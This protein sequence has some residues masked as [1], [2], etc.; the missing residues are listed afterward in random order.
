MGPT[1]RCEV[2]ER[3]GLVGESSRMRLVR[4]E[5]LRAAALRAPLV[6]TGET[7]TGKELAARA[8]HR[9]SGRS[10]GPFVAL[11]CGS[12]T[13]TLAEDALFGHERGA[14]TGAATKR[15][16]AFERA[17]GGTLFLDE[18]GELP[19]AQQAALLRVL[20]DGTVD[21]LGGES[22]ACV[23]VRLLAATNRDLRQMVDEGGFRLDLYH[24]LATLRIEM[25]PLRD[26]PEDVEPLARLFLTAMAAELGQ[27]EL[28]QSA[29]AL[30]VAHAWPGNARELKNALYRAAALSPGPALTAESFELEQPRVAIRSRPFR[31][32]QVTDG[33]IVELL[34]EHRGNVTAA[35]RALGVPRSTVR[36]RLRRIRSE[37]PESAG[38]LRAV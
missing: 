26:R 35:A 17:D 38:R 9:C 11:N 7:G 23:D 3:T 5:I 19:L 14:F 32:E 36:D 4:R 34:A 29:L 21:R 6:I 1:D 31:L 28:S 13:V 16:G 22:G 20:D 27:R 37:S 24:R 8:L 30:L 12:L 33:R 25:P 15:L 10:A 2:Q 18:I